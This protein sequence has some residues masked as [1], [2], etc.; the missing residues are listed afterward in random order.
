MDGNEFS[1][2]T[3]SQ[4]GFF[5][6]GFRF[7]KFAYITDIKDYEE[8]IFTSLEGVET[9]II[10]ALHEEGSHMHFSLDEAVEF[11]RRV[12]SSRVV[13]THINHEMAHELVGDQLPDGMELG[14]DGMRIDV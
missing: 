6:T 1:Y 11:G 8:K 9:I 12:G 3:Y 5:V 10:S 4:E 13:F 14:Y 7:G 2:F